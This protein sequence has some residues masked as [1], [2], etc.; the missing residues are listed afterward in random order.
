MMRAISTFSAMETFPSV[1]DTPSASLAQSFLSFIA[2]SMSSPRHTS[3]QL[4]L[5][6]AAKASVLMVSPFSFF[7]VLID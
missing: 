3:S 5:A 1:Y 6:K 2:T 7:V 4:S